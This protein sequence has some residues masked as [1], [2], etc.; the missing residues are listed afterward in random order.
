MDETS[1]IL[2]PRDG[3]AVVGGE[4]VPT[5]VN[6]MS[7][8]EISKQIRDVV[9]MQY[10][11][12]DP[13]KI[14]MTLLEAALFAAAKKAADGDTDALNKLLD[15]LMGKP[16]QTVMQATGTL[17]EFLNQI[18]QTEGRKSPNGPDGSNTR[19]AIDIDKIGL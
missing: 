15:R 12:T 8:S 2:Y 18:A 3:I 7:P 1:G 4:V 19:S 11:G 10:S 5:G 6:R 16:M 14:G 17:A 9:A 13:E